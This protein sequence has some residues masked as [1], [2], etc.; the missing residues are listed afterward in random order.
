[1]ELSKQDA[2]KMYHTGNGAVLSTIPLS[3][4]SDVGLLGHFKYLAKLMDIGSTHFWMSQVS[5][6][7]HELDAVSPF[8]TPSLPHPTTTSTIMPTMICVWNPRKA[9]FHNIFFDDLIFFCCK[10][11]FLEF[12][13]W[14]SMTAVIQCTCNMEPM[15][16]A[17]LFISIYGACNGEEK[18]K[19]KNRT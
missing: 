10:I 16:L 17:T 6:T 14:V 7:P 12:G 9:K 19:K 13:A 8:L 2:P 11:W 1:M 15:V 3:S 5:E 4:L 18:K